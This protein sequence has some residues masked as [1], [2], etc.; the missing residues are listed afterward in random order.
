VLLFGTAVSAITGILFGIAPALIGSRADLFALQHLRLS[1]SGGGASRSRSVLIAVEVAISLVLVVGATLVLRSHGLVQREL[2]FDR[3]H[4]VWLAIPT[5]ADRYEGAPRQR[6]FEDLAARIQLLPDVEAVGWASASAPLADASAGTRVPVR[7]VGAPPGAEPVQAR[8]HEVSPNYLAAIGVPIVLGRN[9]E[10]ADRP[11]AAHAAS[12]AAVVYETFARTVFPETDPIGRR[13]QSV[14]PGAGNLG[15]LT[16]E[17]VGVSRDYR[18]ERPPRAIAPLMQV[19]VPLGS[20]NT[21]LVVRTSSANPTAI[22]PHVRAIVRQ[23]DPE[24]RVALSRSFDDAIAR[25]LGQEEMYLRVLGLFAVL[26]VSMAAI[27]LYGLVSYTV[28]QRLPE[29][30]VRIA[31]GATRRQLLAGVLAHSLRITVAGI[32]AGAGVALTLTG[33][34]RDVLY[35]IRPTDPTTFV[36]VAAA[37]A[38]VALVAAAL[39]ARR[40]AGVDPVTTLRAE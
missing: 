5:P 16:F 24:L 15:T 33:L 35:G 11:A 39:P 4:V 1:G 22:V 31:L 14:L 36:L 13:V 23:M 3:H 26:A 32:V 2:G 10:T 40:A 19:Y 17:V 37:L 9:L 21:P 6:F 25:G 38:L 30:G 29:L 12:Y 28:I 20:S 27:G 8:V 18:H 7:A 34:I